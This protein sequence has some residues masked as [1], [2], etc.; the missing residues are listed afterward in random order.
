[1]G[2]GAQKL[3][4]RNDIVLVKVYLYITLHIFIIKFT[5]MAYETIPDDDHTKKMNIHITYK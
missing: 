3:Y 4:N 5:K 2:Y 1:M